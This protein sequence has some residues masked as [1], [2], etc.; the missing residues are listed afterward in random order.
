MKALVLSTT[1]VGSLAA[2]V[3]TA[4]AAPT[5]STP[6]TTGV[7]RCVGFEPTGANDSADVYYPDG[8]TA[9]AVGGIYVNNVSSCEK[10]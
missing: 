10:G 6:D 7:E 3:G 2:G 9:V 5:I 4:A 8:Q 1:I